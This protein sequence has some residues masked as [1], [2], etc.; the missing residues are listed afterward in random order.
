[1]KRTFTP[2][3]WTVWAA[4]LATVAAAFA[5]IA[6]PT[7]T[8]LPFRGQSSGQLALALALRSA[9]PIATV[10][11]LLAA[12]AIAVVVWRRVRWLGRVAVAVALLPALVA[13]WFAQQNHFEWMFRPL[14]ATAFAK[15]AE[16]D[17][18]GDDE[19]VLAVEVD[20]DAVAFPVRQLA[21]HHLVQATVGDK[22]VVA[23]Y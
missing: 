8:L 5:T 13:A 6:I 3:T 20:G 22:E 12:V 1:M 14:G 23:T 7:F 18:V 10:A 11:L 21:Y 15:V 2:P 17:F 4:L 16:A 9:A 19:M